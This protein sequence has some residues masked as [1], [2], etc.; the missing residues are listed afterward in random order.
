MT[1]GKEFSIVCLYMPQAE[2]KVFRRGEEFF[3]STD[4]DYN[5]P[6]RVLGGGTLMAEKMDQK[7]GP[8]GTASAW[9]VVRDSHTRVGRVGGRTPQSR[10]FPFPPQGT[11]PLIFIKGGS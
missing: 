1:Q 2:I 9:Q 11:T 3:E 6:L 8:T 7:G 4:R 10:D 5:R